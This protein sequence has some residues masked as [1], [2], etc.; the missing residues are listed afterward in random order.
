[1]KRLRDVPVGL[2]RKEFA[3]Y[4]AGEARTAASQWL[5]NFRDHGPLD[6]RSIK[7]HED[8]DLFVATVFYTEMTIEQSPQYFP[9]Y[10]PQFRK[11][12]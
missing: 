8:R 11:A 9:N 10:Q 7:T 12:S 2:R 6:I 1:M 4:S 3:A 5:N